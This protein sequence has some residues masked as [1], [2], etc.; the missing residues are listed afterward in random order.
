[1]EEFGVN[2]AKPAIND[3]F[4]LRSSQ[5][6]QEKERDWAALSDSDRETLSADLTDETS[7]G[8]EH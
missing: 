5:N 1:M 4:S 8:A 2:E 7:L 6:A 3:Q